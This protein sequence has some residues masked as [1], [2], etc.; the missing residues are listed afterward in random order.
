M[1]N[2]AEKIAVWR[3]ENPRETLSAEALSNILGTDLRDVN[4][5]GAD[6][7][8][9]SNGLL[10]LHGLPSGEV[11]LIPTCD[12]W[13]LRVGYW[14]ES[15][16]DLEKLIATNEGWPKALG[17]ECDRRRPELQALITLCRAHM[18]ANASIIT[19]LTARWATVP[20]G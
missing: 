10:T 19:E 4:L 5:R 1:T 3:E 16:S 15:V 9:C 11:T 13:D 18:D 7:R 17:E 20:E 6:L 12:G 2:N 14:S 8:S